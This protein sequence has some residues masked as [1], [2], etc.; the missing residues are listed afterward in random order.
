[1]KIKLKE[2][3]AAYRKFKHYFYFDNTNRLVKRKIARFEA[4]SNKGDVSLE[5]K[6][7]A[8]HE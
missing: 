3:E 5:K 4:K 8:L 1:M 2:I 6:L 7:K